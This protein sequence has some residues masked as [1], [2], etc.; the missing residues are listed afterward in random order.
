MD[1]AKLTADDVKQVSTWPSREEQLSLL[2]GQILSPGAKLSSQLTAI[3]GDVASQIKQHA[4]DLEKNAPAS[5]A[6][7]PDAAPPPNETPPAA[8][9]PAAG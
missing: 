8:E 5:D 4:E 7:P 1:G 2:V 9:L 3:A 6:A